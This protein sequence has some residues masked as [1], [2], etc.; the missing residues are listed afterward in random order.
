M[1]EFE[2]MLQMLLACA[3]LVVSLV[4]GSLIGAMV[5]RVASNVLKLGEIPFLNALKATAL[6]TFVTLSLNFAAGFQ[7]GLALANGLGSYQGM[8]GYMV[9]EVVMQFFSPGFMLMS[10][11]SGLFIT[12]IFLC[13][14]VERKDNTT[15]L[16]LVE[17]LGLAS[18]ATAVAVAAAVLI[19]GSIVALL[20]FVS[21][22]T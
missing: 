17:G 1:N 19:L 13:L 8:P 14:V 9:R 10:L 7:Q 5:V 2:F 21:R 22:I 20:I 15:K 16:T 4:V 3:A 12:A 6:A 18:L 11:L